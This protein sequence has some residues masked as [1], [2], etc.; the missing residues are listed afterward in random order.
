MKTA[1]DDLTPPTVSKAMQ[2][3]KVNPLPAAALL[4]ELSGLVCEA[5]L[6][7]VVAEEDVPYNKSVRQGGVEAPETWNLTMRMV[8][9]QFLRGWLS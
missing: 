4:E 8:I 7:D 6:G 1:F 5:R 3:W 2:F 9:A